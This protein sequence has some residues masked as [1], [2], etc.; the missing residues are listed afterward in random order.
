MLFEVSNTE[1]SGMEMVKIYFKG[2]MY[3]SIE[4]IVMKRA[5]QRCLISIMSYKH[6]VLFF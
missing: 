3:I 4:M 6:L 1:N 5:S 2:L